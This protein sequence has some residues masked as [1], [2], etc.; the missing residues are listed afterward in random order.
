MF[1]GES[2]TAFLGA[3]LATVRKF[4]PG[5]LLHVRILFFFGTHGTMFGTLGKASLMTN[6]ELLN[7]N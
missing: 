1:E 5:Q 3:E 7:G 2:I 4:S 6:A